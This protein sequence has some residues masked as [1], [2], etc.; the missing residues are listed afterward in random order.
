[1]I[2]KMAQIDLTN[3]IGKKMLSWVAPIYK[4]SLVMKIIYQALGMEWESTEAMIEDIKA[5]LNPLTATWSLGWWEDAWSLLR[6]ENA[7]IEQR[8]NRIIAKMQ[9]SI[10]VNPARMEKAIEAITG[11]TA[12]I[13]HA[14][15][16]TFAVRTRILTAEQEA[17]VRALIED[18]KPAHKSY[19][20]ETIYNHWSEVELLSWARVAEFNWWQIKHDDLGIETNS[21]SDIKAL[22][23]AAVAAKNWA[24]VKGGIR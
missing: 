18:M 5:Q 6:Q 20:I 17:N 7:T 14:A 8:R 13:V 19:L 2:Q 11:K 22:S 3:E 21:W 23:W 10:V 4:D 16:Y 12:T 1:M 15:A 24:E 9:Q